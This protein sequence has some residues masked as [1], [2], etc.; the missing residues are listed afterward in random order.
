MN[1]NALLTD[2]MPQRSPQFVQQPPIH[3]T[4]LSNGA[5][6]TPKSLSPNTGIKAVYF[7]LRDSQ[8]DA[9]MFQ[10][11]AHD[12]TDSIMD[13]I[14]HMLGLS[15]QYDLG[16]SLED[17]DGMSFVPSYDNF[18]DGTTVYVRIEESI[19]HNYVQRHSYNLRQGAA[20]GA[21]STAS[22]RSYGYPNSRS[23]SPNSRGRRSASSSGR[24]RGMKRS[25]LHMN[26]E[27]DRYSDDYGH[28]MTAQWYGLPPQ[29][30]LPEDYEGSRTKA[31]SVASADISVENI[32][33]GS[34]RKRPKFSSDVRLPAAVCLH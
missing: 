17:E 33:E 14:K 18:V 8:N 12:T 19:G 31:G 2:D 22:S 11:R 13:T 7:R 3:S 29:Q 34:R 4:P 5:T 24:Q 32:L 9:K 30:F 20:M 16:I 6:M 27:D 26:S 1:V 25:S 28:D 10:I 23:V 21:G 15:R